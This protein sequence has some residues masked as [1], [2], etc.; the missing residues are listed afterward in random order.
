MVKPGTRRKPK[1]SEKPSAR[2]KRDN[3]AAAFNP[4][5]AS[6]PVTTTFHQEIAARAYE[7]FLGRSGQDGDDLGDWFRAEADLRREPASGGSPPK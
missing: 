5:G 2:R 4:E 6:P 3:P 7:L 1:V